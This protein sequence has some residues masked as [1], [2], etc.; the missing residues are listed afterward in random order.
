VPHS[1]S[2]D[3]RAHTHTHTYEYEYLA[4]MISVLYGS[5]LFISDVCL[6]TRPSKK[7][8]PQ[9]FGT[10]YYFVKPN[11]PDVLSNRSTNQ[12]IRILS[13][14]IICLAC[15]CACACTSTCA[16]SCGVCV[17]SPTLG[18][19]RSSYLT[20]TAESYYYS[21]LVPTYLYLHLEPAKVAQLASQG[22]QEASIRCTHPINPFCQQLDI[23]RAISSLVSTYLDPA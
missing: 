22:G 13:S 8:K 5:A 19:R 3:A 7:A 23:E 11:P 6:G 16:V 18:D 20:P 1:N 4:H 14:S 2:T 21:V 15:A 10:N 17:I 9:Q 12:S